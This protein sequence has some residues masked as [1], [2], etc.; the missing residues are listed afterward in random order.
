VL[1]A[2]HVVGIQ[3]CTSAIHL[4][5]AHLG[6]QPGDEVILSPITWASV[7]NLIVNMGATPVFADIDPE[8]INLDAASVAGRITPRTRAIVPV[9]HA[10]WSC[11]MDALRAV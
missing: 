1:E 3:N 4:C 9:H 5:L 7:G 11:D 2:K 10:G 8:T 6:I